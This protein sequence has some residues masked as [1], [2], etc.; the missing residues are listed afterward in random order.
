MRMSR[1]MPLTL[2]ACLA[3]A[4]IL[5]SNLVVEALNC[6]DSDEF[7]Y[8]IMIDSGSSGSRLFFYKWNHREIDVAMRPYASITFTNIPLSLPIQEVPTNLPVSTFIVT[9]GISSHEHSPDEAS[10]EI[11]IMVEAALEEFRASCSAKILNTPIFL[12]ATAGMRL[13]PKIPRIQI[14]DAIRAYLRTTGFKFEDRYVGILSGGEEAAFGWIS[15]QMTAGTLMERLNESSSSLHDRTKT[16][17]S[18]DLGGASTQICF[19]SDTPVLEDDF[20]IS[21]GL[22]NVDGLYAKSFLRFGTDQA[23]TMSIEKTA[24]LQG[25]NANQS[26]VQFPCFF[27]GY[28]ENMFINGYEYS[29][30]GTSNYSE[31][32][33]LI[34]SLFFTNYDQECFFESCSI[35]G[36]YQP[37]I[38]TDMTFYAVS[39]FFYSINSLH[40][41]SDV[42]L[43]KFQS[44]VENICSQNI[45]SIKDTFHDAA[46]L[47][48]FCWRAAYAF[49]ILRDGYKFPMDFKNL[50]FVDKVNEQSV[51]WAQGAMLLEAN[52]FA[53]D[54]NNTHHP[55]KNFS[56]VLWIALSILSC[57][58]G[59]IIT[60]YSIKKVCINSSGF[61]RL[62]QS[63]SFRRLSLQSP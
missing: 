55:R 13:V 58:I 7:Q 34:S 47:P 29:V 15:V 21:I 19:E 28:K 54:V 18:L 1:R 6:S 26:I 38:P 27:Q 48:Y 14:L 17:G 53:F 12:R 42:S 23:K 33:K 32:S 56:V 45:S 22:A 63:S 35:R 16:F 11:K 8:G 51:S 39:S 41:N 37:E 50:R 24:R 20:P 57:L 40:L 25:A 9:P 62:T 46:L 31:C 10:K 44:V 36:A 60:Y 2:L 3:F 52:L 5:S 43:Y 4:G 59:C 61:R 49:G 30:T